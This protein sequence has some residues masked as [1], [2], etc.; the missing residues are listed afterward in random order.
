MNGS[1]VNHPLAAPSTLLIILA[2]APIMSQPSEGA[3][4]D[5]ASGQHDNACLGGRR[6]NNFQDGVELVFAPVRA[7]MAAKVVK[8]VGV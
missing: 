6:G 4:H 8:R 2:Q 1:Q 7:L 3:F 5:P